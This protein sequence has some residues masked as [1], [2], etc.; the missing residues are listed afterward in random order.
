MSLENNRVVRMGTAL[1]GEVEL[2]ARAGQVLRQ[3]VQALRAS[4]NP[5]LSANL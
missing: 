2:A 1:G 4:A 3:N 5:Y